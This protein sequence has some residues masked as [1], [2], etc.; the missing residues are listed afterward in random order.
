M[1]I[2]REH[3]AVAHHEGFAADDPADGDDGL[4]LGHREN[5]LRACRPAFS[6]RSDAGNPAG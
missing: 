4:M 3:V 6:R 5:F 1:P 2:S